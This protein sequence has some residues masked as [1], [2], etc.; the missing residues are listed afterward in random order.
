MQAHLPHHLMK[1]QAVN[2]QDPVQPAHLLVWKL[3]V[4]LQHLGSAETSEEKVVAAA[5]TCLE[6]GLARRCMHACK[7]MLLSASSK[8]CNGNDDNNNNNENNNNNNCVMAG[9][10]P[11]VHCFSTAMLCSLCNHD[12]MVYLAT[13]A[14]RRT[15][16]G[17]D[18]LATMLQILTDCMKNN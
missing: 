1:A 12:C 4:V 10:F 3:V 11:V 15:A 7:R 18:C 17:S 6:S 5:S 9:W 16:L 14:V 2:V 13:Q 8:T